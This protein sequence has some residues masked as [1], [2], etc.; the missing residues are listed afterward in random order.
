MKNRNL[1]FVS[2]GLSTKLLFSKMI[3]RSKK[4]PCFFRQDYTDFALLFTGSRSTM[5]VNVQ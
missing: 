1:S 3:S 4:I 2:K 5:N